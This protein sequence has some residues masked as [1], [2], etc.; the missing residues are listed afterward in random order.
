METS[1]K[2][3]QIYG[4][5]NYRK[6]LG[7][8]YLYEKETQRRFSF[9]VFSRQAGFTSPNFLKL[10]IEGKRNLSGESVQK[11][12]GSLKLNRNES[13]FFRNLVL[14][15]QSTLVEERRFYAEQLLRSREYRKLHPLKPAQHAY[16]SRWYLVPIRELV[17]TS[18]FRED[19]EWIAHALQP[20]ISTA[21]A[22]KAIETLLELGLLKRDEKGKLIQSESLLSTGDEV[23][24]AAVGKFHKEMI[25]KG[26]EAID[27]FA[28]EDRD[29][30]ALTLGVSR[31]GAQQIKQMIQRFRKE[32][33]SI[34]SQEL[35][36]DAVYQINFQFFPVTETSKED[37]EDSKCAS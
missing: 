31:K 2:K 33:L 32:I 8:H 9:R 37:E 15:N 11:L 21:D 36:A 12:V 3:P 20:Q 6:F 35:N 7:D 14:L 24:S 25:Q 23:T 16:Y 1:R 34:A 22:R 18:H 28:S 29:I 19:A 10:I 4:Y 30:S 5:S 26:S 13:D 27:R 17:A